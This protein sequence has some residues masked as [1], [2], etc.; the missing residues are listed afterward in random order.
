MLRTLISVPV[1]TLET[2]VLSVPTLVGGLLDRSGRW[3]HGIVRFW[4][5][6]LLRTCGVRIVIHGNE[7]V[8]TGPAVFAANHG[9][10]LDIPIL[11]GYLPVEF[12]IIHKRS[13]YWMPLVG[14][15]LYLGGHIG[16]DRR[17]PFRAKRGLA[18][19]AA[20]IRGGT[21]VVVFPE[22]TRSRDAGV[23]T[24]KRGSFLL[25]V[26]AGVPVVPVSLVGVKRVVPRGVLTLRAGTIQ[27][28]IHPP[29][30]TVGRAPGEAEKMAEEVRD[31]VVRGCQEGTT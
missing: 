24:F 13:L 19:A 15:H 8:P 28:R 1:I 21:S 18:A 26:T 27:V 22:G 20:R 23:G 29:V 31:V 30:T 6:L 25:A 9:S 10:A 7:N 12:R 14:W 16:L 4:S 2:L 3:P 5:R 11:F 17:Q